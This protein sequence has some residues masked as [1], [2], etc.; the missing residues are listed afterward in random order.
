MGRVLTTM[1]FKSGVFWDVTPYSLEKPDASMFSVEYGT[2]MLLPN[3]NN[4]LAEY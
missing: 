3:A 2:N 4:H 1:N